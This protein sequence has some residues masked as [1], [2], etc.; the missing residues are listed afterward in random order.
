MNIGDNLE[1]YIM[2]KLQD[3]IIFSNRDFILAFAIFVLIFFVSSC[4]LF[5]VFGLLHIPFDGRA[6]PLMYVVVA[7]GIFIVLYIDLIRVIIGKWR[8]LNNQSKLIRFM[9]IFLTM[10]F[11]VVGIFF[12]RPMG[13]I[14][15]AGF[16]DS[17]KIKID[18]DN[19]QTWLSE[20]DIHTN[21]KHVVSKSEC[22]ESI[23]NLSPDSVQI[24]QEK[25]GTVAHIKW[26]NKFS[27]YELV[28]GPKKMKTPNQDEYKYEEYVHIHPISP[29]AYLSQDIR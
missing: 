13:I 7:L 23:R 17:I 16:C 22:P 25:Y 24:Y 3:K 11:F 28:I 18:V 15:G 6:M 12:F 2:K 5:Y 29:G 9:L 20:Q 21:N 1:L 27:R 19:I 4:I 26:K 10:I 14:Y 8:K